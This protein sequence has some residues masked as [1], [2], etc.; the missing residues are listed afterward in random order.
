MGKRPPK[1]LPGERV[2]ETILT[3]RKSVEQLR[4]DRILQKDK[5]REQRDRLKAKTD[6][7]RKKRLHT[8]KFMAA[9]VI[10]QQAQRRENNARKFSKAGEK[11]DTRAAVRAPETKAK[12]YERAKVALVVRAKGNMIPNEVKKG[13]RM[14][15]LRKLYAGR[16]VHLSPR[17][18]R[19]VQ[20]LKPFAAIGYPTG[21]QLERLIRTRGCFWNPE[22]KSKAYISGNLQVEQTLGEHN[23]LSI[24]ELVDAVVNKAP[25]V[26]AVLKTLAP[27]DFHP[28]RRLYIERHR[29]THQ[30]LEVMNPESFAA[31][32]HEQLMGTH[33]TQGTRA[34][35]KADA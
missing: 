28:P 32:L 13:F 7:K 21:E 35:K 16:L 12:T 10:L 19:L 30:K 23:I 34:A 2:N 1:W 3:Q 9:Q 31:Y 14:L 4:A 27:F 17:T 18:H 6:A 11:F 5:K 20:Q 15:G 24:E 26:D 25:C 29:R 8:K 33:A 22:T